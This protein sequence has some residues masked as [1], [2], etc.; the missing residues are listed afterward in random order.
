MIGNIRE[1]FI[2]AERARKQLLSPV[3]SANGLTPGQGQA[4][5]LNTLLKEDRLNQK[6]LSCRCHMDTTTMSR[7]IDNLE[8]MGLLKREMN[9]ESRRSVIIC[10]TEKGREK[11]LNIREMFT[12]FENILQ[13]DISEEDMERFRSVLIKICENLEEKL[14]QENQL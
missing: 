3:L 2:R 8:K 5:I 12:D 9:P 13:K 11:A 10:L 1:L 4:G 6:E 14:P 7:N